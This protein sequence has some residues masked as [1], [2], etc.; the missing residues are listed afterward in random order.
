MFII[1]IIMASGYQT[2]FICT[3][4]LMDES[5]EQE[6]LYRIQFMQAFNL[7]QW[8]DH[9]VNTITKDLY[10]QI[11]KNPA[12][13]SLFEKARH[14][15]D[16]CDIIVLVSD[17]EDEDEDEDQDPH[18]ANEP[19]NYLLF[20]LLFR[21][22]YFDLLHRCLVEYLRLGQIQPSTLSQFMAVLV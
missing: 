9:E 5:Y 22:E 15:P 16:L 7:E 8:S 2:D 12:F 20:N 1:T 18:L 13:L 11:Y 14:V 10:R 6:D 4:K 21:F 3:Y 17:L 19:N